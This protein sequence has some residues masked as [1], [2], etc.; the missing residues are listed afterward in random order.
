MIEWTWRVHSYLP[1]RSQH[2]E[3]LT[4]QMHSIINWGSG[5]QLNLSLHPDTRWPSSRSSRLSAQIVFSWS[6]IVRM[7]NKIRSV[8]EAGAVWVCQWSWGSVRMANK[9][10]NV[11]EAEQIKTVS[12]SVPGHWCSVSADPQLSLKTFS[13]H[14]S[15]LDCVTGNCCRR[16]TDQLA[17]NP[18]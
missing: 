2:W 9:I 15:S 8:L 13:W 17:S 18:T 11:S 4:N 12:P 7:A 10:R 16:E 3:Y 5:D 14:F 6:E 1:M